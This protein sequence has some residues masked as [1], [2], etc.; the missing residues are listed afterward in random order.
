MSGAGY[1]MKK[2]EKFYSVVLKKFVDIPLSK[3]K[4]VVRNKRKFLV[5]TY[6]AKGKEYTA[7]KVVGMAKVK[8]K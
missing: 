6:Q 4:E 8:K 5:G 1:K 7:W 3:I 2:M